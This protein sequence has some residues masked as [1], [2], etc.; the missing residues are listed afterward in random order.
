MH[1]SLLG[2]MIGAALLLAACTVTPTN[3]E[4]SLV[5]TVG[6][7]PDACATDALLELA[8]AEP[9]TVYTCYTITNEGETTLTLHD[10]VD[11]VHGEVLFDFEYLL[12]PGAS[13]TTVAAGVVLESVVTETTVNDARWDG[14]VNG[15]RVAM[16]T[17]TSEVRL[18][19][20]RQ[21]GAAVGTFVGDGNL[22]GV[23]AFAGNVV[24]LGIL[25]LAGE[26]ID[27][28]V[29]VV[30]T[31]PGLAPFTY[32]FDPA[33]AID[34]EVA[35]WVDDFA[36]P[37]ALPATLA[38]RPVAYVQTA[39]LQGIAAAAIVAGDW[40]FAFPGQ[41]IVR[42]VDASQALDV[43]LV[44]DVSV[45]GT[46]T[47]LTIAFDATA[48]ATYEVEAYGTDLNGVFGSTSGVASPVTVVLD[49]ALETGQGF[50]VDLYAFRGGEDD[51]YADPG[52]I[53]AAAYLHQ[54]AWE[55]E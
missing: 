6:I 22:P 48:G 8:T 27:D 17:A 20:P 24:V 39:P 52:Q 12:V 34:G 35:L 14:F 36:A 40:T 41:T 46:G 18:L 44:S 50:V 47:E 26:P 5:A 23:A 10:L 1:R 11:D 7:D 16:A 30:V 55:V 28:T 31:P 42:T 19:P 38:G 2:A 33:L 4:L 54:D 51:L 53:D 3:A 13:V 45:D 21:Y 25:D 43:P 9:Q 29:A 15:S 32:T 49:G 37:S